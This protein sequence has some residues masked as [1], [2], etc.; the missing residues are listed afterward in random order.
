MLSKNTAYFAQTQHGES[1]WWSWLMG[2]WFI[3]IGW[4][5]AQ[6]VIAGPIPNV[7]AESHPEL[8]EQMTNAFAEKFD[9]AG[10]W[11]FAKVL[12]GGLGTVILTI[13]FW[14][15]SRYNTG[16]TQKVLGWLTGICAVTSLY[17]IYQMIAQG[18]SPEIS[19]AMTAM[20]GAT[21][22]AYALM[23]LSFPGV[24]VGVYLV[25]KFLHKRSLTSLHTTASKIDWQRIL[26]AIIVT[27]GVLGTVTAILHFTGV[28]PVKN[29]FDPSRF[30]MFAIATILFIPLQSA[31]EEII[32]RGY[33]NQ[34]FGHFISNKWVVFFIT[35]A[36]FASMHLANPE[37][38]AGAEK[39]GLVH[40]LVM[41]H[42]F[43]FGFILSVIV[44]FED[45]LEAA[46]GLHA[47][48][49]MFAAM[50]VNYEGSVL[51]TPSLFQAGINPD[52]DIPVGI[53]TI[54]IIAWLLYRSKK[55]DIR[56]MD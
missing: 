19:A 27:M 48:N 53:L 51:P 28:S 54:T 46:I 4:I 11:S 7:V 55:T 49:N 26:Y 25:Q 17:F 8:V 12:L 15:L 39:G 14:A 16:T 24:L 23:L 35:S 5:V 37:S 20:I 52:V 9:E 45:G 32:F 38:Q 31:T 44:Y 33:F 34:G 3:V 36:M 56:I 47:G 40:L 21:P 13:I 42:Y 29:T 30:Y 10:I 41:S 18:N 50:F 1:R 22:I 2:F 6:N 43:M